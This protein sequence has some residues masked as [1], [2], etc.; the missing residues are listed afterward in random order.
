MEPP[1]RIDEPADQTLATLASNGD[2]AAFALLVE[3]HYDFI[4]RVAWKWCRDRSAAEDIAQNVCLRLGATIRTW[5]NESALRTWLYRLTINAA[6]DHARS[7]AR[8]V[9]RT[10]AWS[11]HAMALGEEQ[12]EDAAGDGDHLWAAVR[13]L[14]EKQRDA[15]L[16]VYGEE[17]T[18]A[19][20][21]VVMGCAETTISYHLHTARK[22]LKRLLGEPG[23]ET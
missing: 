14:P 20:A 12:E 13:S 21:A 22:R 8:E 9:R 4:H 6:H 19:A 18:H 16:L 17:M 15:V 2:R 3:R 7:M 1:T 10:K 5:R 11:V 23:D